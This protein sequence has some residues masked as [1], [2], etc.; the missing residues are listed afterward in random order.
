M[1]AVAEGDIK[2]TREYLQNA[3]NSA[4]E[5]I[6]SIDKNSKVTAWNKTAEQI[7]GYKQREVL[8]RKISYLS[9]FVN[10]D[11]LT[12]YINGVFNGHTK[13]FKDVTLLSKTGVRKL[14]RISVQS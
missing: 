13:S 4:S 7:T 2:R 11:D 14:V 6:I 1:K 5:I 3:I 8:G 12:G 10:S 9:I